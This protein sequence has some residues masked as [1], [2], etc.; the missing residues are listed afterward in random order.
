MLIKLLSQIFNF[1]NPFLLI[2]KLNFTFN[3]TYLHICFEH[4]LLFIVGQN[5]VLLVV[6]L[7]FEVIQLANFVL[8]LC[9]LFSFAIV[10]S[11]FY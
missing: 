4:S 9:H 7:Y 3:H 2:L 8:C 1:K 5:L 10:L 6:F 11:L